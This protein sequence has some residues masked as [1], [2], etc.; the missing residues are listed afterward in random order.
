[1]EWN[2]D[3]TNLPSEGSLVDVIISYNGPNER[4]GLLCGFMQNGR[5]VMPAG[6]GENRL[7]LTDDAIMWRKVPNLIVKKDGL[8]YWKEE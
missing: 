1:M 6:S 7:D 8:I 5:I 3:K 4:I 2:K